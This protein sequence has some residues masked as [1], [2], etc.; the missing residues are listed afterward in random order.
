MNETLHTHLDQ[1]LPASIRRSSVGDANEESVC[2][3][4][5]ERFMGVLV[6]PVPPLEMEKLDGKF[7]RGGRV[8]IE[9]P[10]DQE[11]WWRVSPGDRLVVEGRALPICAT[12]DHPSC[13]AEIYVE[14]IS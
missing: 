1:R 7:R 10:R 13:Y 11:R 9:W 2:D 14:D 6:H 5:V 4:T 8:I 12:F 3:V